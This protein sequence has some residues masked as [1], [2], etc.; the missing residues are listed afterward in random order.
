MIYYND[1][2]LS[3][4]IGG[5]NVYAWTIQDMQKVCISFY[6]QPILVW[7]T[8]PV[9]AKLKSDYHLPRSNLDNIW[10]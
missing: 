9:Y 5:G 1:N 8:D 2:Q 4:F 3:K 6:N 7:W 10:I